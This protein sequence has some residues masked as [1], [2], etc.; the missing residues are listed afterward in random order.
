MNEL[1]TK[2]RELYLHHLEAMLRLCELRRIGLNAEIDSP[3]TTPK[4]RAEA[5][6]QRDQTLVEWATIMTELDDQGAPHL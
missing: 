6:R 2:L 3:D 1:E 5:T 4:R